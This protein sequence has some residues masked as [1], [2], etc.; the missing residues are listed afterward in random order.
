MST[1]KKNIKNVNELNCTGCLACIPTCPK[2]AISFQYN[3]EGFWFPSINDEKCIN[4]GKCYSVCPSIALQN[5]NNTIKKNIVQIKDKDVLERSASGGA[6]YGLAQYIISNGGYVV[7]CVLDENMMPIHICTNNIAELS[8][9]QGSKY[10]QSFISTEVYQSIYGLLSENKTVL[11]SGTPCQIA[12]VKAYLGRDFDNL[13]TI[14]LICHG[15]GGPGLY[16]YYL[17]CKEKELGEKIIDVR[18]RSRKVGKY[19][20]NHSTLIVTKNKEYCKHSLDDPYG[21]SFYHN[22][23]LRESCYRCQYASKDRVEDITLAVFDPDRKK[24]ML[25]F[26]SDRGFSTMLINTNKAFELM[27]KASS[28]LTAVDLQENY[29]Q[30]NLNQPTL[31][32][33]SRDELKKMH[34]DINHPEMNPGYTLRITFF[35]KVKRLFPQSIK[36]TV[37]RVIKRS[38]K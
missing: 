9:M 32:P 37:K 22:R 34:F 3:N 21:S 19:P 2:N 17:S 38:H 23:I 15:V 33:V 16:K 10:V 8:K 18:F 36:D 14:G 30:I 24:N 11:F 31:R 4:C 26:P 1:S 29:T 13:I 20:N 28:F 5:K 6:F 25:L 7:G 27:Q 12:G 35:D